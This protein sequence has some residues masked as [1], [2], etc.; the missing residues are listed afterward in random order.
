MK[1]LKMLGKE[2]IV[3]KQKE[4]SDELLKLK[5]QAAAGAKLEKPKR[6]REVKKDIARI[7]T[8][9]NELKKLKKHKNE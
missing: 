6:M 3:K 8:F 4:L 7:L 9:H 2:G 1:D 5:T